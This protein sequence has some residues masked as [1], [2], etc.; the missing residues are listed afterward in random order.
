MCIYLNYI[1]V[2]SK[3]E[4]EHFEHIK[5]EFDVLRDHAFKAKMPKC[6]FFKPE[7]KFLGHIVSNAGMKPDPCKIA[8]VMDWPPL[9]SIYEVCSFLGLT[10][11]FRR[12]IQGYASIAH[13]LTDLF[14]GVDKKDRKGRLMQSGKLGF[15]EAQQLQ[16]EFQKSWTTE[17][18]KAFTTL[19]HALIFAPVLV[20]PNF[21]KHSKLV[22]NAAR[23]APVLGALLLQDDR[24][25]AYHS[26]RLGG[27]EVNYS[28]T[29]IEM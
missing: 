29:D 23:S 24:P 4:D 22:S 19:K 27:P 21:D 14:K 8:V 15:V 7:L 11:T 28:A 20:L 5:R 3:A 1:L 16:A 17:C 18:D 6:D 2:F 13:S 26:H 12:Y 9:R 10:N 25:V